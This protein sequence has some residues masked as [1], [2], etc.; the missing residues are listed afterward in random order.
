MFKSL[1]SLLL[2]DILFPIV[3]ISSWLFCIYIFPS[4]GVLIGAVSVIFWIIIF[5]KF[6][7]KFDKYK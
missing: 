3:V 4:Y 6:T 2:S 5:T 7:S 1:I